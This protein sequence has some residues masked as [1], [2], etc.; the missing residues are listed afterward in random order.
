MGEIPDLSCRSSDYV[1]FNYGYL[2]A[3]HAGL[4]RPEGLPLQLD[5]PGLY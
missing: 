2:G 3:M 4:T 5:N 1:I